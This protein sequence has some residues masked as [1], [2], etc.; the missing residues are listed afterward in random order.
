V[1]LGVAVHCPANGYFAERVEER[2]TARVT[3]FFP[4]LDRENFR[5]AR[6]AMRE[7]MRRVTA[8]INGS[9]DFELGR[10]AFRELV[11][12]REAIFRFGEMRTILTAN[13]ATVVD[14]LFA[15]YVH[16]HFAQQKEYQE[17]VMARR[18]YDAL[19]HCRPDRTFQWSHL[20]GTDEY[21]IRI[22]IC[23]DLC[24]ANGA[25]LRALK[26]LD[27]ARAEPT[28]VIEH[29]DAWIQRL[30]RLRMYHRLPDR[31]IFAVRRPAGEACKD[32]AGKV[33]SELETEGATLV[34]ED[35]TDRIVTLAAD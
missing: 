22:P 20:V 25:P 32:A 34:E 10:R 7:E 13:P 6:A 27:L 12:P 1:N 11:R 2:K 33:L 19:K 18:Y 4:E 16:R 24:D 30:R 21:R 9:K 23:S 5:A 17:T 3:D 29:G 26:P 31:F 15:E 28:D 35:D 8:L 14:D